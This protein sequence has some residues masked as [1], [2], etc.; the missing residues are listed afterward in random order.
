[1]AGRFYEML[2]CQLVMDG[3]ERKCVGPMKQQKEP[4]VKLCKLAWSCQVLLRVESIAAVETRD[5]V[6]WGSRDQRLGIL[7]Q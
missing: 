4:S 2:C 7:G 5:L 3:K 6:Y 1:M